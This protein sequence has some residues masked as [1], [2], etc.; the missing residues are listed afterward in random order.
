MDPFFVSKISYNLAN[1]NRVKLSQSQTQL[2]LEYFRLN[3]KPSLAE[4]EKLGYRIG[5]SSDKIKN[6]FQNRRAKIKTDAKEEEFW[7]LKSSPQIGQVSD[8]KV[9]PGCNSFFQPRD[10]Y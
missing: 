8:I 9:Y 6:W 4:R 1:N 5:I 2:L 7:H 10:F 3:S